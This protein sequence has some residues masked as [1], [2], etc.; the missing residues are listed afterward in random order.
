MMEN[1]NGSEF[2]IE[3]PVSLDAQVFAKVAPVLKENKQ[4]HGRKQWFQIWLPVATTTALTAF[5]FWFLNTKRTDSSDSQN[6]AETVP[7]EMDLQAFASLDLDE[8]SLELVNNIEIIE[9][10]DLLESY[11][12]DD[13]NS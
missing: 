1:H 8:D 6:V 12:E 4:I 13:E 7:E 9:D 11:S 10:L 5:S 2:L 3:P